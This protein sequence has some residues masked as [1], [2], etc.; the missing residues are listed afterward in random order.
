MEKLKTY[1][2]VLE[3]VQSVQEW[4]ERD[5]RYEFHLISDEKTGHIQL[6]KSD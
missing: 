2:T 4:F 3:Y 5:D 1:Q 6:F